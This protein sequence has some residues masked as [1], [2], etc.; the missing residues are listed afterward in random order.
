VGDGRELPRVFVDDSA[1]AA[2][3]LHG[4]GEA[5]LAVEVEELAQLVEAVGGGGFEPADG[6]FGERRG[7]REVGTE[8][9]VDGTEVGELFAGQ[10]DACDV[11]VVEEVGAPKD[12]GPAGARVV[13]LETEI[14][15][16]VRAEWGGEGGSAGGWGEASARE[17]GVLG[18]AG[19]ATAER[20]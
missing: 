10:L 13:D 6:T 20:S 9:A 12:T 17:C 1:R 14:G 18:A 4:D 15:G 7:D 8:P 5:G 2:G 3:G 16:A 11:R 19:L